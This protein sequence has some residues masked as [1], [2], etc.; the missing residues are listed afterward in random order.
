MQNTR[1][2]LHGTYLL[3]GGFLVLDVAAVLL[4]RLL[5]VL[6]LEGGDEC[7][8]LVGPFR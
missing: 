7:W 4:G 8:F 5:D 2:N 1:N 6:E 3:G